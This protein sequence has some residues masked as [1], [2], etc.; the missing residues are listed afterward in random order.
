MTGGPVDLKAIERK[1]LAT[2]IADLLRGHILEGRFRVGERLPP[3]RELAQVLKV[4]RTTLREAVK[5]LERALKKN[6]G[7]GRLQTNLELAQAG[8]KLKTAPYGDK[9]SRFGLDGEG[10]ALPKAARGY[11]IRP[12]FRQRPKRR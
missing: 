2:T 5:I 8:K 11:N 10:S 12:G 4:T 9:W 7:D 3:E 6:P 1:P